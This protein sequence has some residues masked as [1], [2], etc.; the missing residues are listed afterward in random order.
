MFINVLFVDFLFVCC[1][2]L[3]AWTVNKNI[4]FHSLPGVFASP[5]G[6]D[7][8]IT[9]PLGDG[10]SVR[11]RIGRD[12]SAHV[13]CAAAGEDS[14][15]L[16]SRSWNG[17]KHDAIDPLIMLQVVLDGRVLRGR[18]NTRWRRF[19]IRGDVEV[20]TNESKLATDGGQVITCSHGVI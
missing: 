16:W 9:R 2:F 7:V 4:G 8:P 1:R 12:Y 20:A 5:P 6:A 18:T 10:G 19:V 11:F 15:G 3:F 17:K 13:R 14:S